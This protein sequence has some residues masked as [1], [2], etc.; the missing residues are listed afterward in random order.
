[1]RDN[2]DLYWKLMNSMDDEVGELVAYTT[3][4]RDMWEYLA[5]MYRGKDNLNR[6]Y[7]LSCAMFRQDQRDRT[8]TQYFVDYTKL[9]A[10]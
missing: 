3:Y 2:A 7:D 4:V 8:V 5:V 10:E 6:I 9:A 1:M